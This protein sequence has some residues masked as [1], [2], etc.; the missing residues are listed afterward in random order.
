TD[1]HRYLLDNL[2]QQRFASNGAMYAGADSIHRLR[3]LSGHAYYDARF[4]ELLE[5]MPGRQFGDPPSLM[6]P[7]R[8]ANVAD[9][10]V[11]D[12]LAVRY[13]VAP[14]W[15]R[16]YGR[17]TPAVDDGSTLTL[18][19]GRPVSVRIPV[20]GPVRGVGLVPTVAFDPKDVTARV[21]V[22]LL[23]G[24]GTEVARAFRLER[25]MVAGTPF[26]IPIAAEGV[27]PNASL[28]AEFTVRSRSPLVVRAQGGRPA[29]TAVTPVDDGMR[30]V[31]AG[32]AAIW[33]RLHAMD[34]VRW[35]SATVVEPD[36]ARRLR[37]LSTGPLD[38][39]TVVLDQPGPA[40][41][42]AD[43]GV[44]LVE[45]GL[46]QIE[47][48]VDAA[49]PGY[50]VVGDAVQRQWVATLDGRPTP[51]V[52]ADHG[53]AAVAVPRGRHTVRLHYEMPYRNAG[54]WITGATVLGMIGLVGAEWWRRRPV[55]ARRPRR[56]GGPEPSPS[57]T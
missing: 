48:T 35:A 3:A 18:V 26:V 51:L 52:S 38:A 40:A 10:A 57:Q 25:K 16:V 47:A 14:P 54:A 8:H 34:R 56:R 30:L 36:S 33:E 15:S 55:A 45:D 6:Y 50:L 27:A 12:R 9:S 53:V 1:V 43:A 20:A 29:V 11:L 23:D 13:Y 4:A 22:R 21:D 5:T 7:P 41:S 44:R 32:S 46:D 2:G 31:H 17:E 37:L 19:S 28:T 42:G 39:D 24:R 49:G